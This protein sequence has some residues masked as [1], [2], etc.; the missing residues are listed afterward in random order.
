MKSSKS[1]HVVLASICVLLASLGI[2]SASAAATVVS[3]DRDTSPP[4]VI[5]PDADP[6]TIE[7]SQLTDERLMFIQSMPVT[8]RIREVTIGDIA[9]AESCTAGANVKLFVREHINGDLDPKPATLVSSTAAVPLTTTP[10]RVTWTIPPTTFRAGRGY[11]FSMFDWSSTGCKRTKT[12]MWESGAATVNAGPSLCTM[13]PARKRADGT[14]TDARSRRMWHVQGMDDRQPD[15]IN[16]TTSTSYFDPSM[17]GGWLVTHHYNG[18]D[19]YAAVHTHYDGNP[20]SP[21]DYCGNSDRYESFGTLERFWRITGSTTTEEWTCYWT[22]FGPPGEPQPGGWHYSVPW[23]QHDNSE[24]RTMYLKLES[25]DYQSILSAR[26]PLL[27]YDTQEDY[28]ADSAE[29][30]TDNPGNSLHRT[31]RDPL[32]SPWYTWDI[33]LLG[34]TYSDDG[35]AASEDDFIDARGDFEDGGLTYLSDWTALRDSAPTRYKNKAYGR[36]VYDGNDKLWLQ[37]WFFYYFNPQNILGQGVH[38][39]DWEMIQVRLNDSLQA[40]YATYAQHNAGESR[41]WIEVTTTTDGFHPVVWVARDSHASYFESGE[42]TRWP[43][44][45]DFFD[46]ASADQVIPAVIEIEGNT[47]PRWVGWMG[48]W[49]AGGAPDGPAHKGDQWSDPGKWSSTVTGDTCQ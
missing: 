40:D 12:V 33:N 37:Y 30:L 14:M 26:A 39:G 17:P 45:T 34:P 20:G 29:T 47:D 18:R 21:H 19:Y 44:P 25:I 11:S 10:Q 48:R 38:E 2:V 35:S 41:N 36:A 27:L 9:L 24:P 31:G 49:G 3:G 43:C 42:N 1:R 5:E 13:A 4:L 16:K 28:R 22:R 6:V 8:K 15:C 32:V 23:L 7:R 46:G